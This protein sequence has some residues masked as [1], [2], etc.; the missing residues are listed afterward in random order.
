[1]THTGEPAPPN[2]VPQTLSPRPLLRCQKARPLRHVTGDSVGGE[3]LIACRANNIADLLL[4]SVQDLVDALVA[5]PGYS[6][7]GPQG[8]TVSAQPRDLC[9]ARA[10][11]GAQLDGRRDCPR[12]V[13]VAARRA[14][15]NYPGN[16]LNHATAPK[17][18]QPTLSTLACGAHSRPMPNPVCGTKLPDSC[19][20]R[21]FLRVWAG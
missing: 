19:S 15:G 7:N 8:S 4:V 3:P 21:P 13:S 12:Y 11:H 9:I 20:D 5:Q 2:N 6:R 16:Y 18:R 10:T 14:L 1:M 17:Q